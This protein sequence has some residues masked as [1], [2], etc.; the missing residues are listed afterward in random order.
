VKTSSYSLGDAITIILINH[1][2]AIYTCQYDSPIKKGR[3]CKKSCPVFAVFLFICDHKRI[4][5]SPNLDHPTLPGNDDY[6]SMPVF[7]LRKAAWRHV[8]NS[9][10]IHDPTDYVLPDRC[11][12]MLFPAS[13]TNAAFP[14]GKAGH[15]QG[16][17]AF[18]FVSG[19]VP[20][21]G[22]GIL[23]WSPHRCEHL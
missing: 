21:Q 3:T 16:N 9:L 11:H 17:A 13:G 23:F 15:Q 22:T 14:P 4:R 18:A 19:V 6:Q 12:W 2:P 20:S 5:K 8:L 7:A 1:S 10:D